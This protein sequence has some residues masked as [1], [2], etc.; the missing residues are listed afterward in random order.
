MGLSIFLDVK[1]GVR[2]HELEWFWLLT[3]LL[4]SV[5]Y[6]NVWIRAIQLVIICVDVI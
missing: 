6:N 4:Y 5:E 2:K 3:K 1:S